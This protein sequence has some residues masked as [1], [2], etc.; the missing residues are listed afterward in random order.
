VQARSALFDLF[1][2][3]LR[4]RGSCAP[5]AALVRLLAPLDVAA[6]AVRTA[7]SRMVRQGWLRPVRLPAGP[8][9]ELTPKAARRLDDASAR[10]YRTR[11]ED[12]DGRWHLLVLTGPADRAARTRLAASLSFLGFGELG[13]HTWISPRAVAEVATVVEEAGARAE[14]FLAEHTGG[15]AGAADLVRRSW[16][17]D[18][19]GKAYLRFVQD[20]TP[21]M[22]A[23]GTDATDE[24]AFAARSE[25]VHTWRRFLFSDPGLPPSLLPDGWPGTAAAAFFDSHATRLSPGAN[26]FV[27]S[28][29]PTG[30]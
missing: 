7:V 18:A 21:A 15:T 5:V 20:M 29:L 17:L 13:G 26:R 16:D 1:G 6:P 25:L 30:P 27:D 14:E 8:G 2:D 23:A 12:W 9:Y 24:Q 10:V 22:E 11:R 3:H 19:L 4:T 28:C